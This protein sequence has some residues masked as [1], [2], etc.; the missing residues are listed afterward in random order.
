MHAACG[1]LQYSYLGS[2]ESPFCERMRVAPRPS[3]YTRSESRRWRHVEY[4]SARVATQQFHFRD[5]CPA[6][7]RNGIRSKSRGEEL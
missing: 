4:Q 7:N 2:A 6:T 1:T 5:G 3:T